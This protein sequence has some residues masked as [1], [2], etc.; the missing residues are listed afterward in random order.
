MSLAFVLFVSPFLIVIILI[1]SPFL[2][3]LKVHWA[4]CSSYYILLVDE[5]YVNVWV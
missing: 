2:L 3:T 4:M 5:L 1:I